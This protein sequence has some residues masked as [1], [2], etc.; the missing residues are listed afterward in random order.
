[1]KARLEE[2]VERYPELNVCR[3]SILA[4][5]E[6]MLACYRQGGKLLLC[7]NGGSAADADHWSGELLKGFCSRRPLDDSQRQGLDPD[8][9]GRLQN[10]LPAIP[11]TSF[12]ALST[13][14]GWAGPATCWSA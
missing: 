12:P 10:A 4:A 13:A 2:L 14:Y 3:D 6:A 5:F 8:L 11:L 1:M 7:G 9:A